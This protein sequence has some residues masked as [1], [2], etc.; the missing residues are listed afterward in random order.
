MIKQMILSLA[1]I[2]V[3]LTSLGL[4][5]ENTTPQILDPQSHGDATQTCSVTYST[6]TGQTATQFCITENGNIGQFS[7]AGIELVAAPSA[8]GVG[9]G[10]GIC[11]FAPN[12]Q[13]YDYGYGDSGNWLSPTLT[14][15]G[16]VVT[17]IR[18]T[19]DGIWQ[20]KQTLTNI[21]ANAFGPA[22]V[23]V[24]MALKNLSGSAR[25]VDLTRYSTVLNPAPSGGG[26]LSLDFDYTPETAYGLIPKFGRGLSTTN[27]T[28]A[29]TH[30]T[31]SQ[32]SPSGP[33]PCASLNSIAPQPFVALSSIVQFWS[34]T[35]P[36]HGS[37]TVINTYKPI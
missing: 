7:I 29:Y 5:Q 11:D 30:A 12:V 3:G 24:A 14:H 2:V 16:N 33:P 26:F 4:A 23:K 20:L 6:G 28:F 17:V 10:Y 25:V 9:E 13:Y 18:N 22:S 36:A 32:I 35:V 8:F 1:I 31:F 27:N 15:N 34:L 19:S 21:P 37:K